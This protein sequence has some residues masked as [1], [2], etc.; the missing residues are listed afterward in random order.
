MLIAGEV[1]GARFSEQ[2]DRLVPGRLG[3]ATRIAIGDRNLTLGPAARFDDRQTRRDAAGFSRWQGSDIGERSLR[4]QELPLGTVAPVE[5]PLIEELLLRIAEQMQTGQIGI[6]RIEL[7]IGEPAV[8]HLAFRYRWSR[9]AL[10]LAIGEYRDADVGVFD[11]GRVDA[12]AL[13]DGSI[14]ERVG[15]VRGLGH[16]DGIDLARGQL[17]AA[18][19]LGSGARFLAAALAAGSPDVAVID[20]VIIGD[21]D[22]GSVASQFAEG[23]I[24]AQKLGVVVEQHLVGRTAFCTRNVPLVDLIPGKTEQIRLVGCDPFCDLLMGKP[25]RR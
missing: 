16:V 15:Q 11:T 7:W 6:D 2:A 13:A 10:E 4:E 12:V 25:D 22:A 3:P 1:K 17:V 19:I 8:D 20:I 18:G 23:S 24:P 5:R 9:C 14:D 21:G